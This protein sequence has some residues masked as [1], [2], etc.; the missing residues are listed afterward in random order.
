[1]PALFDLEKSVAKLLAGV[2][3]LSLKDTQKDKCTLCEIDM[4][5]IDIEKNDP[6]QWTVDRIDNNL[7]HI[8]GN[9]WLACLE[10]NRNHKV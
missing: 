5:W 1:M 10:C 9:V 6:D 3:I 2:C 4:K 8:K 7:D